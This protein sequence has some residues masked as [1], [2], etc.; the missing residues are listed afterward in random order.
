M[1]NVL[2]AR[3]RSTTLDFPAPDAPVKRTI[4]GCLRCGRH[5]FWLMGFEGFHDSVERGIRGEGEADA[6]F[7]RRVI[8]PERDALEQEAR[9]GHVPVRLSE[10]VER[11]SDDGVTQAMHVRADLVRAPGKNFE[12]N[13]RRSA[14]PFDDVVM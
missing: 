10:D 12:L 2:S 14:E 4:G 5:F 6:L 7:G 9:S 3:R 11:V 1:G 8:E 13:E